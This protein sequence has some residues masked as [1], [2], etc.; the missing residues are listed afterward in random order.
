MGISKK[1]LFRNKYL[2]GKL[3]IQIWNAL[4]R[5]TLTYALQTQEL[6]ES[7]ET[8]INGFAQNCMREITEATDNKWII[9]TRNKE[10][11]QSAYSIHLRTMRP[12]ITSWME[13]QTMIAMVKQTAPSRQ[14]HLPT[15]T[16]MRNI[17]KKWQE[18]RHEVQK[19]QK[20]Q[21]ERRT[22][23]N[24]QHEQK[25]NNTPWLLHYKN[26]HAEKLQ[27]HIRTN[28]Q[29]PELYPLKE[30]D[31]RFIT[32][33][34]LQIKQ[35]KTA[36]QT[37]PENR[38]ETHKCPTCQYEGEQEHHLIR[39]RRRKEGCKRIWEQEQ[40]PGW[41]CKIQA[42][43]A[44]F[45]TKQELEKQKAYHNH[46]E[47]EGKNSITSQGIIKLDRRKTLQEGTPRE[48]KLLYNNNVQFDTQQKNGNA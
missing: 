1:K 46:E 43:Q 2:P 41:R 35:Q 9:Q 37:T 45:T 21:E 36:K 38:K 3:R 5:S 12:T 27:E 24:K 16:R 30:N 32:D 31:L 25:N 6:T 11:R 15:Q 42:C 22:N 4:I 47:K 19:Q 39:H 8:K 23:N 26:K 34:M 44:S 33:I 29:P 18:T 40:K 28:Q 13:K 7:Q 48:N 20:Q 10:K 14:L 17:N